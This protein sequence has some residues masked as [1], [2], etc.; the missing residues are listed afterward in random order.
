MLTRADVA[1]FQ[2]IITEPDTLAENRWTAETLDLQ[3]QLI[4]D[5]ATFDL[6]ANQTL[7]AL[8]TKT[9]EVVGISTIETTDLRLLR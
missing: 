8:E 5:P 6:V 2:A 4:E 3:R 7:V 9:S 1:A